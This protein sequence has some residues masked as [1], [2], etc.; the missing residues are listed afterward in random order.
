MKS[1]LFLLFPVY[2]AA[3]TDYDMD[4][5]ARN[6]PAR[7]TRS[8]ESLAAYIMKNTPDERGRIRAIFA[9]V[10]LNVK[11]L[12]SSNKSEIWATPEHLDRQRP[13]RVLE[14]RTAVCQGFANLFQALSRACGIE[15]QVITGIV[16]S[17]E[18]EVMRVGHAW[19]AAR[20]MGHWHL[21]DTTWSLPDPEHPWTVNDRYFMPA[22]NKFIFNHL[23]DDPVWQLLPNPVDEDQFR[24]SGAADI[25]RY[26]MSRQEPTFNY[27]DTL[28]NWT[29]LDTVQRIFSSEQRMLQYNGHNERIIFSLGQ[30][31]WGLFFDLRAHLDSLSDHSI[32][33]ES[34]PIDTAYYSANIRLLWQYYR[35]A[36]SHFEKL[37]EP[38]R[39]KQAEKFYNRDDITCMLTKMQGDMWT[40][41]FEN[42]HREFENSTDERDIAELAETGDQAI[43]IYRKA[44]ETLDCH[45]LAPTCYEL[46]HNVSLI[47]LQMA[48]RNAFFAQQL[49]N[50]KNFEN[51]RPNIATAMTHAKTGF[52]LADRDTRELLK[53]PPV[54]SF[55]RDRL[56]R[57]QQGYIT[58]KALDLRKRQL[59]VS[60]EVEATLNADKDDGAKAFSVAQKLDTV[61]DDVNDLSNYLEDHQQELG[62]DF[63][64]TTL[65][66]L[67]LDAYAMN[68]NQSSLYWRAA[69]NLQ[70]NVSGNNQNQEIRSR[71]N[72]LV[73]QA[74]SSLKSARQAYDGLKRA[75]RLS[76]NSLSQR[77]GQIDRLAKSIQDFKKAIR[78]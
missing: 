28:T 44:E 42:K 9:W 7:A 75:N 20:I 1:F 47:E 16:K 8:V 77:Q 67:N 36:A 14:N 51:N 49:L 53:I 78:Q 31:Y 17:P 68:F 70:F 34:V 48:E 21:F 59:M 37:T 64:Q 60:S 11:Y 3:Q 39:V 58:L 43:A 61:L 35:R 69:L 18:G 56:Q 38:A 74:E 12:D 13:E 57:V 65:F 54:Y 5:V 62:A 27:E 19:N 4:E 46:W 50:Q 24:N 15:C 29:A 33:D 73:Q 52:D 32:M 25:H 40:A 30:Q 41:L 2:L 76:A 23:P 71:V 63:C 22:S 72:D 6:A 26:M 10:T 66:N 45:K 55:V